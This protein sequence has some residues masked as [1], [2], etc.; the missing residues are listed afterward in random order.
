MGSPVLIF[1]HRPKCGGT[2]IWN[3]LA[4]QPN[5]ARVS[6]GLKCN[7]PEV[8][9]DILKKFNIDNNLNE[10]GIVRDQTCFTD[11]NEI[12]AIRAHS[13]L[14][15]YNIDNCTPG[16]IIV[17]NIRNPVDMFYSSF[18]HH[19]L[20]G[21]VQQ[22]GNNIDEYI[23]NELHKWQKQYIH[24]THTVYRECHHIIVLE[25]LEKT[26]LPVLQSLQ[27]TSKHEYH[28]NK[29]RMPPAELKKKYLHRR[30]EVGSILSQA[31]EIYHGYINKK[32]N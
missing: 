28:V 12:R 13:S 21:W 10:I 27:V 18:Y 32:H 14:N 26:I 4:I 17:S 24:D 3:R 5:T 22:Y 7:Y 9:E 2:Y 30:Y 8:V 31:M 11:I 23:D 16:Q 6:L 1:R 25:Q 15:H 29:N 20:K 19:N